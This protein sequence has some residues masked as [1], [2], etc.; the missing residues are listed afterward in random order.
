MAPGT[1]L[2]ISLVITVVQVQWKHHVSHVN[3]V[4]VLHAPRA[5]AAARLAVQ[6]VKLESQ[7]PA[8]RAKLAVAMAA[9]PAQQLFQRVAVAVVAAARHAPLEVVV[10]KFV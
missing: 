1:L 7:R 5:P 10:A 9:N 8:H 4:V 6:L 2:V 3:Q